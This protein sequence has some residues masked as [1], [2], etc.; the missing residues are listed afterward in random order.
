MSEKLDREISSLKAKDPEG[1]ARLIRVIKSIRKDFLQAE[2]AFEDDKKKGRELY[3]IA[4]DKHNESLNSIIKSRKIAMTLKSVIVSLIGT[5]AFMM[6]GVVL[7]AELIA[8]KEQSEK[9][10]KAIENAFDELKKI[11][12]RM[13]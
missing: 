9:A 12:S 7:S 1:N 6:F 13:A 5:V 11:P 8:N 4:M 3:S 2:N 10:Q